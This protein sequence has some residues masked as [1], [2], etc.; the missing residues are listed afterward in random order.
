MML[1]KNIF[2]YNKNMSM[3]QRVVKKNIKYYY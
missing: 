1:K 3:A 2:I